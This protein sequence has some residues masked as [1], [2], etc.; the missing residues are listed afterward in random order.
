LTDGE[1]KMSEEFGKVAEP[2]YK[3]FGWKWAIVTPDACGMG[4][5]TA[6]Q[7][8]EEARHLMLLALTI[9]DPAVGFPVCTYTQSGGIT[10]IRYKDKLLVQ[11]A[12]VEGS[13]YADT[14]HVHNGGELVTP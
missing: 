10:V 3:H 6:A 11:M 7:I 4:V 12:V 9:H 5:P 1:I 2:Y 13:V 8:A 14:F